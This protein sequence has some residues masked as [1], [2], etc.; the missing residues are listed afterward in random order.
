MANL[1][2]IILVGRLTADPEGRSTMDGIPMTKFRLV[3]ARPFGGTDLIDVIAWRKAAETCSQYLKKGKLA[4]VEGRIQIR[5]FEDQAGQRRWATEV[6]ARNVSMLDKSPV[7]NNQPAGE[8]AVED[9]DLA[10]DLPF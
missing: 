2:R 8:E 7:E 1:N 5:S 4:L 9:A 6:V 3:V 10:S